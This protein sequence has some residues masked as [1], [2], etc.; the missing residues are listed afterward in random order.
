MYNALNPKSWYNKYLSCNNNLNP[1]QMVF[2]P[3]VV[4]LAGLKRSS[5][6]PS[7]SDTINLHNCDIDVMSSA[8]KQNYTKKKLS[9]KNNCTSYCNRLTSQNVK[10]T[11]LNICFHVQ[12]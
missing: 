10:N 1:S 7:F 11:I 4:H 8:I 2:G 12:T 6:F 9:N 3:Q 5:L